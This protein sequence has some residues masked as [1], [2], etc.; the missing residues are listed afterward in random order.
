MK[1]DIVFPNKEYQNYA[2]F[3]YPDDLSSSH[4]KINTS[5]LYITKKV[6]IVAQM[7]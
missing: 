4:D 7:T 6:L 5:G 2:N 3:F 1:F